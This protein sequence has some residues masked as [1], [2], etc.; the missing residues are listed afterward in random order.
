MKPQVYTL[1]TSYKSPLY[2]QIQEHKEKVELKIKVGLISS[3]MAKPKA[4]AATSK[5]PSKAKVYN[6]EDYCACVLLTVSAR[7]TTAHA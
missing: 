1:Y 7:M 6:R 4:A 3:P 2:L 5:Q